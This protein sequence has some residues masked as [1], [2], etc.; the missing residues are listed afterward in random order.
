MI[1]CLARVG[2]AIALL[3]AAGC[4]EAEPGD[5]ASNK[6][7]TTASRA[8]KART[9]TIIELASGSRRWD[10]QIDDSATARDFLDQLPLTL[11]LK[12]YGGNEKIADLP[13]PLTRE[14][15]PDAVTPR[16]GDVAFYAP[17]VNLAIFYRDGHHSPG[18]I[19]LGR[20]QHEAADLAGLGP[21]TV[22]IRRAERSQ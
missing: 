17:W 19:R 9:M 16:A 14:G 11:A 10:A 22:T 20:L 3:G 8:E 5:A 2:L 13:R 15:A 12:D 6:K 18:L 21:L 4:S 1:A 7:S